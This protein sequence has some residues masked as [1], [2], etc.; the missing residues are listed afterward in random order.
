MKLTEAVFAVFHESFISSDPKHKN[1]TEVQCPICLC[2]LTREDVVNKGGCVDHIIPQSAIN[3]DGDIIKQ[4][5]ARNERT[6]LA[7][8]CRRP[9][10]TVNDKKADQGCNGLKGSLYDT[11]FAGFLETKQFSAQD[12]KIKHQV[13][14]LVM[15]YLGA[16]QNW[17]YSYILR[18]ELDEIRE[19]FDNPGKIVSKWTSSVQFETAPNKIVPI[20]P[21][22]GQPFFFYEDANDLVVIFRRFLARL[23]GKPKNSVRVGNPYGLLPAKI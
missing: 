20:T 9:R 13:A 22:K 7:L 8:L 3:E 21:G 17:G 5:I 15:A 16:F 2:S 10:K 19:Q 11:L 6:G 14:I 23:P 1:S 4:E 18:S 12:L